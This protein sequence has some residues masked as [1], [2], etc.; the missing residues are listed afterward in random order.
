MNQPVKPRNNDDLV[1]VYAPDG[2]AV[3]HTYPNARDLVQGAGYSWEK[4]RETSP[5]ATSPHSRRKSP[6]KSIAEEVFASAGAQPRTGTDVDDED[7][8]EEDDTDADMASEE[9]GE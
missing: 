6:K 2:T 9:T 3:R 1:T 5:A 7:V 4:G 8:V